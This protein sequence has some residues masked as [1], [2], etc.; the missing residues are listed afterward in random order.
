MDEHGEVSGIVK[1]TYTGSPA[2]HWRQRALTGDDESLKRELRTN[3]ENLLPGGTDIKVSSIEKLEDFEQPLV[4]N[5]QV[6]GP[7]GSATGKR[8][9]IPADLF[10]ANS[11]PTFPN[12]KR[13]IPVYFSYAHIN[14]DAVR[15][16]FPP[17]F[18]VESLPASDKMSFQQFAIYSLKSE[19]TP[20][21]FTIRRD[22]FL[23]EIYFKTE[24]YPELRG[25]YSKM[26][27]KDQET[28]ILTTAPATKS[29]PAGN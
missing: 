24:E 11:K 28:V 20:N 27:N 2:L 9:L 10:E 3:I 13:D 14:Q 21:S 7:I 26:E 1:M 29:T 12:A 4:V 15:I 8:L 5:F 22:Y 25:F 6:K 23:G 16:T 19:S 17:N 18:T